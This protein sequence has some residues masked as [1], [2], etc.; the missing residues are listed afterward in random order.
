MQDI[1]RAQ[2]KGDASED[3]LRALEIDV[4]GKIM[5][6]SWRGTRFEVVQ[7][8]REVRVT[9]PI[10]R[11]GLRTHITTGRRQRPEGPQRQGPRAVPPRA[12]APAPRCDLQEHRA[13]RVGRRAPR[14][15]TV[16]VSLPFLFLRR[17][18]CTERLDTHRMVAEAAKPKKKQAPPSAATQ[19]ALNRAH[20]A[21]HGQANGHTP[22]AT[23]A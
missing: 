22:L 7:V 3:E 16:R 13:G 17:A 20:E 10:R 21:R 11:A 23:D 19:A 6:A 5:L 1:E 12:R 2:L 9:S 14:A 8:L 18:S 4:T 15:R